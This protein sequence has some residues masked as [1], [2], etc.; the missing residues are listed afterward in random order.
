MSTSSLE[1]PQ[2]R[3]RGLPNISRCYPGLSRLFCFAPSVLHQ[4][5][6]EHG[7]IKVDERVHGSADLLLC[8]T[9]E[10]FAD[11]CTRIGGAAGCHGD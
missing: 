9:G 4:G 1:L 3:H 8:M 7:V 2:R 10:D 11:G 6:D 5:V